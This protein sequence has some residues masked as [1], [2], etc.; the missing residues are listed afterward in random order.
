M[1]FFYIVKQVDFFKIVYAN[2]KL[3][4]MKIAIRFPII[5]G[6]HV[7]LELQGK[8]KLETSKP[9][10]GTISFGIGGYNDLQYFNSRRGYFGIK[11]GGVLIFKG[12]AHFAVH[13]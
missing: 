8:V 6:N 13:S 2:F 11:R 9:K 5:V 12:R 1:S 7:K 3:F 10:M 4:P